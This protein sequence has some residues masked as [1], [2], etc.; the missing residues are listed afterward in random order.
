MQNLS[1]AI[2]TKI[3]FEISYSLKIPLQQ[4]TSKGNICIYSNN[5]IQNRGIGHAW[6]E[7]PTEDGQHK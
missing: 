5:I 7:K 3:F 1:K 2:K 4:K 6:L